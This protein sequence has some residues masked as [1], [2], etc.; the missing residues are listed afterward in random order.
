MPPQEIRGVSREQ[1]GNKAA[2][3]V[4]TILPDHFFE[5][6]RCETACRSGAGQCNE[7]GRENIPAFFMIQQVCRSDQRHSTLVIS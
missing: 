4:S 1:H 3:E 6:S 2:S 7:K 5:G